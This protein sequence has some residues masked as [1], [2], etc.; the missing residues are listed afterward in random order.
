MDGKNKYTRF[1]AI[2][3]ARQEIQGAFKILKAIPQN[4]VQDLDTGCSSIL[5][6]IKEEDFECEYCEAKHRN[7]DCKIPDL[8][9]LEGDP[10]LGG[11]EI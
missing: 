11:L 3:L 7:G 10:I 4:D 8:S 2:S 6:P 1:R 9:E 5:D